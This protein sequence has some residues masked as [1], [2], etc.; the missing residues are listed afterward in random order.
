MNETR[1]PRWPWV[2]G[3]LAVVLVVTAGVV[4]WQRRQA[5]ADADRAAAAAAAAVVDAWNS[6]GP[7]EVLSSAPFADRE[8]T[9]V[10]Y[11]AI[12]AGLGGARPEVDLGTVTRTAEAA[13]ADLTLTWPFG[14]EGWTYETTLDLTASGSG[15]GT[16]AGWTATWSPTLVHPD[17]AEAD[18]LRAT[19]VTADRAD[20]LG[21]GGT[22]IVTEQPVVRVGVQPSRVK[23]L[24]SLTTTLAGLLDVDAAGLAE[25]VSA[26]GPT[27]FVDVITLRQSDFEALDEQLRPLPGTVFAEDTQPLAPTREFAR[28]LLGTVGPATAEVVEQS[29]GRVAAGDQTGLSGLQRSYDD[30]LAGSAGV[31]VER[32]RGEQATELF[33]VEAVAGTPVALTLDPTVQRAA[34][35]AL[36]SAPSGGPAGGNGNAALVAVDVTTGAVLA[37]ANTPASGTNRAMTGQYPPGSTFKTI[38]TQALLAAGVTPEQPVPCPKTET[39][40]GRSFKNFE[41]EA[42]GDVTFADDFAASC[43]TA[44]VS[45]S[46]DLGDDALTAAASPMGIGLDW[47]VGVDAFTGD[48][49]AN[50]SAVDK[51]AATIGQGRTLV[52]PLGMAVAAGTIARGEFVDPTLVVDPAEEAA[53][54]T[55]PP[56]VA[57]LA[58]VRSLM[59]SVVTGGTA[60]ALSDVPGGDVFAKTGTAEYGSGDPPPTHAWTIGFRGNVAF[61][62]LVED[63]VSGGRAA[64]PVAEVF[65][66]GIAG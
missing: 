2:A 58:V 49:P 14:P 12:V 41:G 51:A 11:D 26:A 35:A 32:V 28:A 3:G 9:R 29:D 59:R 25:R 42:L 43:N 62:V 30:Q 16:A 46:G 27:A 10:A 66:R 20:V 37:V 21:A 22:S 13:T 61:A 64:V 19:R 65:L 39:V 45:L 36:A 33:A 18:A 56:P 31:R 6:D 4:V 17:L 53:P 48:V 7:A 60:S 40:D 38:S 15:T 44:F 34:D 52:S 57:D 55:A 50:T 24:A 23:D 8:A 54:V 5:A 47:E 63:G 1:R